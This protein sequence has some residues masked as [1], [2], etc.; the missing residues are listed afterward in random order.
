MAGSQLLLLGKLLMLGLIPIPGQNL[1]ENL[2]HSHSPSVSARLIQKRKWLRLGIATL[3]STALVGGTL[4]P[5][6]TNSFSSIPSLQK[7]LPRK[8]SFLTLKDKLLIFPSCGIS[9]TQTT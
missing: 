9:S 6:P 2:M 1:Q 5:V 4:V 3:T 7:R 8:Q